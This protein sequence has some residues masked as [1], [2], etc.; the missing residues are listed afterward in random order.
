MTVSG[1]FWV[2]GVIF[3]NINT[4]Q[5]FCYLDFNIVPV[6]M[7]KDYILGK[8]G[9]DCTFHGKTYFKWI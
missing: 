6:L 3:V 9:K 5:P 4:R 7:E 8:I 1:H 2:A